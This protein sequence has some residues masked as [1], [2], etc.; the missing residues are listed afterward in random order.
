[1]VE[2]LLIFFGI[3]W[4]NKCTMWNA[5]SK[6]FGGLTFQ[7]SVLLPVMTAGAT[8]GPELAVVLI[9]LAVV[10][11]VLTGVVLMIPYPRLAF[12][13]CRADM[14]RLLHL[15]CSLSDS[16][17]N[18]FCNPS[19]TDLFLSVADG[20][21]ED[22][23]ELLLS[24]TSLSVDVTAESLLYHDMVPFTRMLC[25][26]LPLVSRLLREL[27]GVRD[28]VPQL[29][30]NE[31][32]KMFVSV[33]SAPL[34][35][36]TTEIRVSLLQLVT[37]RVQAV[38][39]SLPL[40][41]R[42]KRG[43]MKC[44]RKAGAV[45][46]AIF[47]WDKI[48]GCGG[49]SC[50]HASCSALPFA[51]C[52][53]RRK[54]DIEVALSDDSDDNASAVHRRRS[55]TCEESEGPEGVQRLSECRDAVFKALHFAREAY[56][57]VSP[58]AVTEP[59]D[60]LDVFPADADGLRKADWQ[61]YCPGAV[62]SAVADDIGTESSSHRANSLDGAST[63]DDFEMLPV[64][65][66]DGTP[67]SSPMVAR[68]RTRTM[69]KDLSIYV[70]PARDSVSGVCSTKASVLYYDNLR[71]G[72]RN[73]IPRGAFICRLMSV[74]DTVSEIVSVVWLDVD[75]GDEDNKGDIW[76]SVVSCVMAQCHY[77]WSCLFEPGRIAS[78]SAT[79]LWHYFRRCTCSLSRCKSDETLA[80][81][82]DSSATL[83]AKEY[84]WE[85]VYPAKMA[86]ITATASLLVLLPTLHNIF[87]YGLWG[88]VVATLIR[89]ENSASSF[90]KGIQ[91][92]KGTV[93]GCI[94]SYVASQWIGC[95]LEDCHQCTARAVLVVWIG[96]CAYFRWN[97]KYGYAALV[98]GFTPLVIILGP[99]R[100][101]QDSAWGR[102]EMTFI[103]VFLYLVVDNLL[104]PGRSDNAL[105]T[106]AMQS[107]ARVRNILSGTSAVMRILIS[108][109][110]GDNAVVSTEEHTDGSASGK[111]YDDNSCSA[112]FA[113]LASCLP[114]AEADLAALAT[115]I[116]VQK[117]LLDLVIYEPRQ[118][119]RYFSLR[120]MRCKWL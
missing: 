30:P 16:Y 49:G 26:L 117:S 77:F 66:G 100:G 41:G 94:F 57:F 11:A 73:L 70:T 72:A 21:M 18:A 61:S 79:L 84:L 113:A 81:P 7:L 90:H 87:P 43:T 13:Q 75:K 42:V 60:G 102:V 25:R 91:R 107:V 45:C 29:T 27:E 118:H 74:V 33:L 8:S 103:G 3:C 6:T 31:T 69:S 19:E 20:H 4:I 96:V 1:M 80:D 110:G 97:D 52:C 58:P 22:I 68:A 88:A 35:D 14:L 48:R 89:Q 15:L 99:S 10:P 65:S 50:C 36:V 32:H 92:I 112:V 62:R 108:G 40:V 115:N 106:H 101:S 24:I 76:S 12:Y 53:W 17:V 55:V 105:R 67:V 63:E 54:D 109:R 119:L 39:P 104:V 83:A 46:A 116:V 5:M 9:L 51:R 44:I 37:G 47:C 34:T 93:L 38:Q 85:Y 95:D 82:P 86:L 23:R 78:H 2:F 71:L 111:S 28:M 120:V 114:S 64:S 59:V 56:V 98:A